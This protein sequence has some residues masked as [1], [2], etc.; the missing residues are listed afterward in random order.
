MVLGKAGH[1]GV[2]RQLHPTFIHHRQNSRFSIPGHVSQIL[3][4][5][6]PYTIPHR[7][8]R[9]QPRTICNFNQFV[10]RTTM[11]SSFWNKLGI[12]FGT[13]SYSAK[14]IAREEDRDHTERLIKFF[15]EESDWEEYTSRF[16]HEARE[17]F[18][19]PRQCGLRY[20]VKSF[21]R[22]TPLSYQ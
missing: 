10:C 19:R 6:T 9:N 1:V 14:C 20:T 18:S 2:L 11:R 15:Q 21:I 3:A 22:K 12:L 7:I 5:E 8:H 16:P 13:P 17:S 4:N